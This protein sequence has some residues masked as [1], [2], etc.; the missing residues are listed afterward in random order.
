MEVKAGSIYFTTQGQFSAASMPEIISTAIKTYKNTVV[1]NSITSIGLS[2]FYGKM[3]VGSK[4]TIFGK[5]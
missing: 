1:G 5:K 3:T 2:V 4:V